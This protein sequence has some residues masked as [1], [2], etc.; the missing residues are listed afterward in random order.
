[1]R[2]RKEK[3]WLQF[4]EWVNSP[5]IL[6]LFDPSK[7]ITICYDARKDGVECCFIQENKHKLLEA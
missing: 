3:A 5:P 1:M 4:K 2:G 7:S 6:S